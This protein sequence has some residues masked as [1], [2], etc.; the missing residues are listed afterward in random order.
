MIYKVS[1]AE[2]SQLCARELFQGICAVGCPPP[3]P[4]GSE[5]EESRLPA[6]ELFQAVCAVGRPLLPPSGGRRWGQPLLSL[7]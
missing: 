7:P 3:P 4:S 5:A 6:R 1:E 2:G